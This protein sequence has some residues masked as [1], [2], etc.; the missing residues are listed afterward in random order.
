MAPRGPIAPSATNLSPVRRPTLNHNQSS[1]NLIT[2]PVPPPQNYPRKQSSL[3]SVPQ[4]TIVSSSQSQEPSQFNLLTSYP[5]PTRRAPAHTVNTPLA[6]VTNSSV[7][8]IPTP[9]S[10]L[11]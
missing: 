2:R 7:T 11:L 3:P 9:I 1:P 10:N 6:S 4:D 8:A 5:P